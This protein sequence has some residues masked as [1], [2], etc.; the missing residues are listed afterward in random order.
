MKR[1]VLATVAAAGICSRDMVVAIKAAGGKK[2]LYHEYKGLGHNV[3][4]PTFADVLRRQGL[5]MALLTAMPPDPRTR[6][7]R[8]AEIGRN[9]S[10][11]CTCESSLV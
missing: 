5:R 8:P 1:L 11:R 7:L 2:I 6:Q 4:T 9:F 3:W 10:L